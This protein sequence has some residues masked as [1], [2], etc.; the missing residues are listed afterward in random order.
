MTN[1]QGTLRSVY[2]IEIQVNSPSFQRFQFSLPNHLEE[3]LALDFSL[4]SALLLLL[5]N[6]QLK[7]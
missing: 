2:G 4:H 3:V 7:R 6:K 1:I 5:L